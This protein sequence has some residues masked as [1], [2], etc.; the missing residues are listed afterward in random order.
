MAKPRQF[1]PEEIKAIAGMAAVRLPTD[2]IATI[3]GMSKETFE[4]RVKKDSA[5]RDAI[6]KGRANAS[7]TIRNTLYRMATT[8]R[9]IVEET[10]IGV[11]PKA[12]KVVKKKKVG[13]DVNALRFWCETQEGFKR[14]EK[15]ELSGPG[16][17]PVEVSKI[18]PEERKEILK[19]YNEKL[20]LTED[21]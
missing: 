18:S 20:A 9:E 17:K 5:L 6:E 15:L 7:G 14:T 12:R 10:T 4:R 8:D 11:G 19:K 3:M 21:E 2:Q 16:G 13:P 1:T